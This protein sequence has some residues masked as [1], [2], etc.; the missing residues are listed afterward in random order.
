MKPRLKA[1]RANTT[2]S[3]RLAFDEAAKTCD[4]TGAILFSNVPVQY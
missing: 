4:V 3:G 2:A 1:G